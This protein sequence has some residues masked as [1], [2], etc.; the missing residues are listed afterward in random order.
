[1]SQH[2][3]N[4]DRRL[5]NTCDF[6]SR[7]KLRC[8]QGRPSCRR[9]LERTQLCVYSPV[10][11]RG[12]PSKASTKVKISR[13]E[14]LE[15]RDVHRNSRQSPSSVTPL[16][17]SQ[18]E[19]RMS[20][21]SALSSGDTDST[22]PNR[23]QKNTMF[24][25]RELA[26]DF[27]SD[28]GPDFGNML[29]SNDIF[30]FASLPVEGEVEENLPTPRMMNEDVNPGNLGLVSPASLPLSTAYF[31]S[32]EK[33]IELESQEYEKHSSIGRPS[34]FFSLDEDEVEKLLAEG[35]SF[36]KAGNLINAVTNGIKSEQG[37]TAGTYICN[38]RLCCCSIALNILH[39]LCFH[40]ALSQQNGRP[41][42]DFVL[43][44][45][46]HTNQLYAGIL[47]CPACRAKSLH[48]L[49]FLCVC[50]D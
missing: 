10:R 16:P 21:S 18:Y 11:R 29:S 49:I 23:N 20:I 7:S 13:E 2:F 38:E 8:D 32:V 30:D 28:F 35:S 9:C 36:L 17:T 4:K 37:T 40:P 6:C 44:L 27:G 31:A 1:M 15:T 42:L 24:P 34:S 48:S 45:E 41:P 3:L 50:T 19:Q 14:N 25:T 26:V 46:D 47:K 43:L 39:L 22:C 5:R 12:R 33:S